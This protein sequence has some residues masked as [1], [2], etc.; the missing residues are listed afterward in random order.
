MI[1]CDTRQLPNGNWK[2][3]K[4]LRIIRVRGITKP[5]KRECKEA[6]PRLG[7]CASIGSEV[8][9]EV[10]VSCGGNQ[11]KL[12]VFACAVHDECTMEK[13]LPGVKCC[14]SCADFKA[15]APQSRR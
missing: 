15:I 5:P 3:A 7:P 4:C 10:C 8:R 11:F 13:Q 2:C 12:K 1:W 14:R 9:R 6:E